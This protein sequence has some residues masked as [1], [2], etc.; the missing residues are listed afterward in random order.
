MHGRVPDGTLLLPLVK[1]REAN[2][3]NWLKENRQVKKGIVRVKS[4]EKEKKGNVR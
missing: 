2:M 4:K 3:T 1:Q